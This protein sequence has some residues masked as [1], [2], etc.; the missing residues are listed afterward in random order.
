MVR[1]SCHHGVV[2]QHLAQRRFCKL[3]A[4]RSRPSCTRTGGPAQ[5]QR[6]KQTRD[7]EDRAA[8]RVPPARSPTRLRRARLD[9]LRQGQAI[10]C[11]AISAPTCSAPAPRLHGAPCLATPPPRTCGARSRGLRQA[12]G[13]VAAAYTEQE[14]CRFVVAETRCV[15]GD[16]RSSPPSVSC[17]ALLPGRSPGKCVHGPVSAAQPTFCSTA[18]GCAGLRQRSGQ[19]RRRRIIAC[20]TT[21]RRPRARQVGAAIPSRPGNLLTALGPG[22]RPQR[23][24]HDCF[25]LHGQSFPCQPRGLGPVVALS[26]IDQLGARR[27]GRAAFW[28]MRASSAG[29]R[30]RRLGRKAG[31][32]RPGAVARATDPH[33]RRSRRRGRRGRGQAPVCGVPGEPRLAAG[34]PARSGHAYRRAQRRPRDL[35]HL[36]RPGAQDH[37][38]GRARALLFRRRQR[39]QSGVCQGDLRCVIG[40]P[41]LVGRSS[42]GGKS[43]SMQSLLSTSC[44][45]ILRHWRLARDLSFATRSSPT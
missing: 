25:R 10:A 2:G 29:V 1:R 28:A 43:A 13:S 45:R 4:R 14:A 24:D 8:R 40:A 42:F 6:Q 9:V 15:G 21:A 22:S 18:R 41:S 44:G 39:R 19:P 12:V 17:P 31:A 23:R 38:D 3:D 32:E 36:A 34:G 16:Q 26:R 30:A 20:S 33:A 7:G 5:Q 27:P 37:Q 11:R 35:R